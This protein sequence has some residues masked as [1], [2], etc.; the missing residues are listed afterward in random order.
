MGNIVNSE[1]G[2]NIDNKLKEAK[3]FTGDD[4]AKILGVEKEYTKAKFKESLDESY[5][6]IMNPN[7]KP[8]RFKESN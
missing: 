1:E 3:M 6:N 8:I 2:L 5:R 7:K 4:L